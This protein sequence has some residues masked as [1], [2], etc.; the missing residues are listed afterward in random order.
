MSFR[1]AS[2]AALLALVVA[3]CGGTGGTSGPDQS[4]VCTPGDFVNCLCSDGSFGTKQCKDDGLSFEACT[5]CQGNTACIPGETREC[6]CGGG[7][8]GVQQCRAD[9]SAF[10]A[11]HDCNPSAGGA[12]GTGGSSAGTGGV[13]GTG[14][15]GTTGG[16]GGASGSGTAGSGPGP[17]NDGCPGT[18]A[19]VMMGGDTTLNG[20]TVGAKDDFT[21]CATPGGADVVYQVTPQ[22]S[23]TLLL[24]AQGKNGLDPAI[25]VFTG[26]CGTGQ[27]T[28]CVDDGA[29][30][31]IET[32]S[33]P[34][35]QGKPLF[36]VVDGHGTAGDFTLTLSLNGTVAGDKCPGDPVSLTAG[37]DVTVTGD[38]SF[39]KPDIVGD[40]PCD[41]T[42]STNDVVY[43]LTPTTSGKVTAVLTPKTG[44]DGVL[45][46]RSGACTTGAQIGCSQQAGAAGAETISFDAAG[47][48][49]YSVVVDG[50]SGSQGAYSL[51]FS[52]AKMSCGD[53][54]VTPDEQCDDG[55][56]AANDGCFSCK[57]EQ[58]PP[59]ADCPGLEVHVFGSPTVVS[60]S[61]ASYSNIRIGSCGGDTAKDRVYEVVPEVTG[62]LTAEI[63]TASYDAVLYAREGACS[64]TFTELACDDVIGNGK[65]KILVPV[66]KG[67]S[68]WVVV[69]GYSTMSGT[70]SLQLS[71]L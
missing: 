30:N 28:P 65:E 51:T 11:C 13:A 71:I 32:L 56:T 24:K 5:D 3:A 63:V 69:D 18:I 40:A 10:D 36:V 37:T 1:G 55:N 49:T 6:T 60:G 58:N 39:A 67:K 9:G 68:V 46:A 42:N 41:K 43:A 23:G 52:L 15:A 54:M 26:A 20:T 59:M 62:T 19:T 31:E 47:G 16:S 7:T 27:P 33:V 48:T 34:V 53:G 61:T 4:R 21:T 44:F 12:A 29:E 2:L 35:T 45:Y 25:G 66:T 57:V 50:Q 70:F 38:T 8:L 14:T 64:G 22:A 17:A